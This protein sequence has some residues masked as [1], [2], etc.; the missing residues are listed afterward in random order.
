M[1]KTKLS[2]MAIRPE[3]KIRLKFLSLATG[4]TMMDYIDSVVSKLWDEKKDKL[5]LEKIPTSLKT[6]ISKLLDSLR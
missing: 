4:I 3:T 5:T 6:D 2:S 1:N